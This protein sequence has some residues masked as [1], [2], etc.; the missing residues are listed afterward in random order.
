MSSVDSWPESFCDFSTVPSSESRSPNLCFDSNP[1]ALLIVFS[2]PPTE[3]SDDPTLCR[4]QIRRKC[5]SSHQKLS[6]PCLSSG[7]HQCFPLSLSSSPDDDVVKIFRRHNTYESEKEREKWMNC[8]WR[9]KNRHRI[10]VC[11][12]TKT[13][14]HILGDDFECVRFWATL[15]RMC[16]WSAVAI[17]IRSPYQVLARSGAEVV[18]E[19]VGVLES[20][21]TFGEQRDRFVKVLPV[22]PSSVV[23]VHL[24]KQLEEAIVYQQNLI[25]NLLAYLVTQLLLHLQRFRVILEPFKVMKVLLQSSA[26]FDVVRFGSDWWILLVSTAL[27]VLASV[28]FPVCKKYV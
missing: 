9:S 23:L 2:M 24:E 4:H 16:V 12:E 7:F 6:L 5:D 8:V 15:D 1:S 20:V 25:I 28:T 10:F 21:S 18:G 27:V 14:K 13:C 22:D 11:L 17:R 26:S 3:L 19:W